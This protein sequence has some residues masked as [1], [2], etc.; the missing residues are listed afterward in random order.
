MNPSLTELLKLL[1]ASGPN[2]FEGLIAALLELLTGRHFSLAIS[3]SQAGRDMSSRDACANVVAVECKRYAQKTELDERELLGELVQVTDAIPDLDL[4]VLATSRDVPSQLREVLHRATTN[5]GVGF[6]SISSADGSP[7]SLEVLFAFSPDVAA[8]H[9]AWEGIASPEVIRKSLDETRQQSR[10]QERA[11]ELRSIFSSPLIGYENWRMEQNAW[12]LHCLTLAAEAHANFGQLMNVEE[13]GVSLVK[14]AEVWASMS[15]W[16]RTWRDNHSNLAVVGE[17]GDG[18]TWSVASWLGHSIKTRGDFP[19]IILL[20]STDV[21]TTDPEQLLSKAISRRFST[22]L[23]THSE[24][25]LQ[26]WMSRQ[27]VERPLLL[28]VLDGIN[29]RR[30]PEWWRTLLNKLAAALWA[31]HV[32]VIITSRTSY[33]DRNFAPLRHPSFTRLTVPPYSDA[34]LDV[35]LANHKLARGDIHDN[36]LPLIRKPRYFDLMIKHRD[37]MAESGDITVARL[38]YE[39]WRDRFERKVNNPL[40]NDDFQDVIRKLA[41]A[42]RERPSLFREQEIAGLLPIGTERQERAF[43]ELRTGGVLQNTGGLYKVK[44][45]VPVYG[46]GILLADQV[47]QAATD[48]IDLM[49]VIASW[50]EPQQEIDIKS[51]ICEFAALHALSIQGFPSTREDSFAARLDRKPKSTRPG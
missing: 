8:S 20:S 39:D 46:L 31:Q 10:F 11:E 17:E 42:S 26:K 1:K 48:G 43:E 24:R 32:A 22:T 30:G 44:E 35:A 9:P 49:E 50:L 5:Q 28:L 23:Q 27:D 16:L 25:R 12:F 21:E 51:S 33:W 14:R 38:V 45:S 41:S 37:R 13:M 4:W 29:E 2:G 36:L 3:G 18:K 19:G 34:E 40:T 7:S 47:E 15:E 6:V